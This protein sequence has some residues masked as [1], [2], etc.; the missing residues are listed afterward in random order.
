VLASGRA[1]S[2]YY[3]PGLGELHFVRDVDSRDQLVMLASMVGKYVRELLMS[4]VSAF[5]SPDDEDIR[6]PSGYHDP[7]TQ[8]FVL[9]TA[10]HRRKRKIPDTCFERARDEQ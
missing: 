2:G 10:L 3:F 9:A 1:R 4:R 5:Y 6:K 7:V 8:R